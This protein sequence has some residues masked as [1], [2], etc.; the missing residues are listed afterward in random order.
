MERTRNKL[1]KRE[2]AF[3]V[4]ER[5]IFMAANFLEKESLSANKKLRRLL[6]IVIAIFV[7]AVA[8]I[9][10]GVGDELFDF[11]DERTRLIAGV[12]LGG[13]GILLIFS[14]IILILTMRPAKNGKNLLL[15]LGETTQ[16][17]AAEIINREV[18]E[19]KILYEGTRD[20]NT[21]IKHDTRVLLTPSYLLLIGYSMEK[22]RAIPCDRI[23]WIGAQT[24]YTGGPYFARLL[25]FTREKM[26]DCDVND[27]EQ[28]KRLAEG[29]YHYIPN[30][31][32]DLEW[33]D[34]NFPH[35][36]EK[37]YRKDRDGFLA[38][39]EEEK[40]KTERSR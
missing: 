22:I 14:F 7:A 37:L 12:L 39:Y 27:M 13:A 8:V 28:A 6:L 35:M 11:S 2:S 21:P 3:A 36:L 26:L 32:R 20:Y 17:K 29:L 18:A 10:F 15:P 25:I 34:D 23:L 1:A 40:E 30:V 38:L 5:K 9:Y 4:G 19:G 31:F 16:E 33:Q 24:G